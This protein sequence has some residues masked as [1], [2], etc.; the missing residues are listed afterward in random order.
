[1]IAVLRSFKWK[2]KVWAALDGFGRSLYFWLL[3]LVLDVLG[4]GCSCVVL[5]VPACYQVRSRSDVLLETESGL[6]ANWVRAAARLFI[7]L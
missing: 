4:F 6:T 1:M 2:L 7:N 3:Q 5:A